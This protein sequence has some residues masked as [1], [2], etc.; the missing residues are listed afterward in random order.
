MSGGSGK[1]ALTHGLVSAALGLGAYYG[2]R[3]FGASELHALMVAA[4]VSALRV[5][6]TAVRERRLDLVAGFIMLMHGT[7]L[8]VAVLTNSV[9]LA[10][11]PHVV[12]TVL[13]GLFFIGSGVVGRPLTEMVIQAVR[14]GWAEQHL[15]KHEWSESDLR[16]YHRMHVWLC[17][18]FGAVELLQAVAM[19]G[20]I[21]HYSVD[22]AQ[23]TNGLLAAFGT[24]ARWAFVIAMIWVFLRRRKIHQ[25]SPSRQSQTSAAERSTEAPTGSTYT[26]SSGYTAMPPGVSAAVSPTQGSQ[27]RAV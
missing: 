13:F 24:S 6:Y 27:P 9:Q 11:L 1:S 4:V 25:G 16:A 3:A 7:T 23:V 8:L 14:P 20:V 5:L 19:V 18:G 10:Q 26:P 22:V 2:M 15:A 21:L 17:V 12:P